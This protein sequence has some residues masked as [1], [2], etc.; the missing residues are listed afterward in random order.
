MEG[1]KVPTITRLVREEGM[2]LSCVGISKSL[3]K[4]EESGSI[5]RIEDRIWQ[6]VEKAGETKKVVG[7]QM[8]LDIEAT[9]YQLH[10]LLMSKDN[11]TYIFLHRVFVF[12]N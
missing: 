8:H 1:H 5:G 10:K 7:D 3:A 9:V 12:V 2:K 11:S 6:T 4:F